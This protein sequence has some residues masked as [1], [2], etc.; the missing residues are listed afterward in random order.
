VS[1]WRMIRRALAP[2]AV[3]TAISLRRATA[4]ESREILRRWRRRIKRTKR[5]GAEQNYQGAAGVADYLFLQRHDSKREAAIGRI[6]LG[7]IL[8]EGER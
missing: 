4:R 8:A 7:M 2:K 6:F 5:D 1:N 3:R